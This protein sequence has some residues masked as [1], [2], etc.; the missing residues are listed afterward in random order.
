MPL[1]TW[2][3]SMSVGVKII[4]EDHKK[5]VGMVNQ[6]HDGIMNG[7]RAEALGKV[8]DQLVSYTKIHF[9]REEAMFAKTRYPAA[10]AHKT[11]HDKLIKTALDLQARYKG[12]ASSML[13]LE[14]MT[15]LK[16][17]LAHHIQGADK[18]YSTHLNTHGIH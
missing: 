10:A 7:H 12:G 1:M 16:A 2:T 9:D 3:E 6:L 4:D 15:F 14:T 17:W 18:S 5:L 13:S 11:E 8:L